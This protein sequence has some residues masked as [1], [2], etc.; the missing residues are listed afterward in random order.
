MS[1][2]D[3]TNYLLSFKCKI[4]EIWLGETACIFLMFLISAFQISMECKTQNPGGK[5]K[6]IQFT[7][8]ENIH[9]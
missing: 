1:Q 7:L 4:Y 3:I 5:Y 9:V 8:T 2:R 6:T